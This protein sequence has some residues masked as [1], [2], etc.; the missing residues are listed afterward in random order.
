MPEGLIGY[1]RMAIAGLTIPLEGDR[2]DPEAQ[3]A[4]YETVFRAMVRSWTYGRVS[5]RHLLNEATYILNSTVEVDWL[6]DEP[7]VRAIFE[8][9][10]NRE[11]VELLADDD[12]GVRRAA[13]LL[14]AR[15]RSAP[16]KVRVG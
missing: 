15:G 9:L 6:W 8:G 13:M 16:K 5:P 10:K 1:L 2:S 4:A 3:R 12:A 14:C 11:W 7:R